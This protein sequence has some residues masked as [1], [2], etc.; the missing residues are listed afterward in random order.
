MQGATDLFWSS[1]KFWRKILLETMFKHKKKKK[2]VG[3]IQLAFTKGND[4]LLWSDWLC[5]KEDSSWCFLTKKFHLTLWRLFTVSHL[6]ANCWLMDGKL[7]DCPAPS[8]ETSGM[9]FHCQR[10][11]SGIP[12]GSVLQPVLK[13]SLLT[14]WTTEYSATSVCSWLPNYR[15]QNLGRL[16]KNLLTKASWEISKCSCKVLDLGWNNPV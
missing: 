16:E 10:D 2:M 11:T 14:I 4:D 12:Q 3:N 15:Q 8:V 6:Q 1:G 9:K 7:P 5:W 13:T